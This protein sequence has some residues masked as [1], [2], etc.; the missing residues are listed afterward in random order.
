MKASGRDDRVNVRVAPQVAGLAILQFLGFDLEWELELGTAAAC[1]NHP[2]KRIVW[3]TG[4]LPEDQI[5]HRF[6]PAVRRLY[7]CRLFDPQTVVGHRIPMRP[8]LTHD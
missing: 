1:R 3:G 5:L 6:L 2:H 7:R 4:P 8:G